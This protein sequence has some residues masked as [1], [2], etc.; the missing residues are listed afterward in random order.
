ML[1][2]RNT[3]YKNQ[4]TKLFNPVNEQTVEQLLVS[5][6]GRIDSEQCLCFGSKF[7]Y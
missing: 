3:L 5:H 7:F 1:L 4:T 6:K 2:L